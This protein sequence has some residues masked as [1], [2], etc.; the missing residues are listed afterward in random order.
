MNGL[1][2]TYGERI[3]FVHANVH[4]PQ[5]QP[6][7]KQYAFSGTPEFYLVDAQGTIIGFWNE[8]PDPGELRRAFDAAL[9]PDK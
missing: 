6:L 2:K 4:D 8:A 9:R 5:S 3:T 7:M 1:E